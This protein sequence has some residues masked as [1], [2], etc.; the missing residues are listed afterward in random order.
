MI[1]QVNSDNHVDGNVNL[2]VEVEEKVQRALDRYADRITRVEVH[3][4]DEN[5]HK[6][7]QD[8]QRCLMEARLNGL[9]PIA[10]THKAATLAQAV[11][12]ATERLRN[13]IDNTLGKMERR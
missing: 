5:A 13:A 7:G 9:Q 2:V 8:D 12:G 3:L 11:D 10:V 1:I 6:N 4:N